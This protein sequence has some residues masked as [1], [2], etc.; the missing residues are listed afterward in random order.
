MRAGASPINVRTNM[1]N[2]Q[3]RAGAMKRESKVKVEG[4]FPKQDKKKGK[5]EEVKEHKCKEEECNTLLSEGSP[6]YCPEHQKEDDTDLEKMTQPKLKSLAFKKGYKGTKMDK[7]SLIAF[8]KST[9]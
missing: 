9:S 6:E 5:K 7:E 4:G 8:L 2:G 1:E 3:M